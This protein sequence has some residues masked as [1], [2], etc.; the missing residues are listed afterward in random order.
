MHNLKDTKMNKLFLIGNVGKDPEVKS[1]EWGK[2]AKFSLATTESYKNKDGQK[3]TET[4]WHNIVFKGR[5]CDVVELYVHKG[6]KIHVQGK[7]KT[8]SYTDKEGATH[9][10]TEIICDELELLGSKKEE[11]KETPKSNKVNVSSMSDIN[12]LPSAESDPSYEPF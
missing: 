6:D 9:W 3:I 7:I 8:R 11:P 10:A 12:D 2:V 5:V 4:E 1:F